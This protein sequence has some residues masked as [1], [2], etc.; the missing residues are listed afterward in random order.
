MVSIHRLPIIYDIP[1]DIQIINAFHERSG[2]FENP[3]YE[4][5]DICLNNLSFAAFSFLKWQNKPLRLAPF[6]SVILDTLWTKTFP[7]LLASRGAGKCIAAD[8]IVQTDSGFSSIK[9][10]CTG[11]FGA[12]PAKISMFGENGFNN[13][14]FTW[15]NKS[16]P[17]Y[18]ITTS[19]GYEIK[20]VAKHRV[21][22]IQNGTIEWKEL[23][24]FTGDEY[25]AISR[26]DSYTFNGD[27]SIGCHEAYLLGAIIGDGGLTSTGKIGFTSKDDDIV[28]QFTRHHKELKY[29]SSFTSLSDPIAYSILFGS[30]KNKEKFLEYYRI[31][32]TL[33]V[34]KKIP[35]S[36]LQSN[37]SA[38][39]NFILGYT[40]T[41]GSVTKRGIEY[42]S[43]SKELLRQLQIILLSYGIISKLRHKNVKYRDRY[44][45]AWILL[46]NRSNC[47]LFLKN[48]GRLRCA[49]KQRAL[50]K[51]ILGFKGNPNKDLMR[52]SKVLFKSLAAV[53][54]SKNSY[55]S[56]ALSPSTVDRY[57]Y[58]YQKA[59]NIL[60]Y[61][62]EAADTKEWRELNEMVAKNLYYDRVS[63][64]EVLPDEVTYDVHI[65]D[66]HTF[67]SNGIISH[68]TF[69]LAVYA[70]LKAMLTPGSKIVIVASSFRQS[71]LVFEYIEKLFEYSP[72]FR[73][74][75]PRGIK[76]PSDS[77]YMDVGTSSI[78]A[79]PLGNGEKI[80]GI[81]ATTIITD[82]F[83]SINPEI[84][85][86]VV[87]GFASVSSNPIEA[88]TQTHLEREAIK[89]GKM[90]LDQMTRTQGNQIIYSG[91]ANYQ[92]N[93]FYKTF[94]THKTII[95]NKISGSSEEV[96]ATLGLDEDNA[97]ADG[98]L[99]YR[100]YAIIRIP[101]QGLPE[102]YMDE[103]QIAQAK[104][105]MPKALFQMEYE[106][107]FPTDS[108]GF[109][110]R[111]T[112]NAATPGHKACGGNPFGIETE[113]QSG[114][115]YVMGIDPARKT[116]N[117]AISVL[118]LLP[119]NET[120]RNVYCYSMRGKSYT[121]AARKIRELLAKFNI[122]RIAMDAGGGGNAIMDI[123]QDGKFLEP[124]EVP[125][126]L[127]DDD[128]QKRYAGQHILDIVDFT[129]RWI[130]DANYGLAS[131]M[132]HKRL[133]FP[134]R[135]LE[136]ERS[137]RSVASDEETV[138]DDVWLEID[139][140]IK[141]T[142]MIVVTPTK[143][144]MQHFD[145]PDLPSSQQ[146]TLKTYQRKDR[147]SALLLATHAARTYLQQGQRNVTPNIG[148]WVNSL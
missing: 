68:N 90:T 81:R 56:K 115:Q 139:E 140:Q 34:S 70:A 143:T 103:K 2:K 110:K 20:G 114:F 67:I 63:S 69:M 79:L 85:Q 97:L 30:Q 148:G 55:L 131:D 24:T 74:C 127:Y 132:E 95:E 54:P 82:E 120:Y 73:A 13:T 45:D 47:K 7:I 27:W 104:V 121:K 106:C 58:S 33:S 91:T 98:H 49:R 10:L 32:Q 61:S 99:D 16:E 94:L 111:S 39:A 17:V 77:V 129:P 29:C 72:M 21:R 23:G 124:G 112:I 6:Q 42:S 116:D 8:S 93:H 135:G 35:E 25:L 76:K 1:K 134:Y 53:V 12:T 123:L 64:I 100:D 14:S 125:I 88:A 37:K 38:L 142:C 147:Y 107:A 50:E 87:R 80:R 138:R 60:M 78:R 5:I 144:G 4:L 126:W 28:E 141:E 15:V 51:L 105:T 11:K 57:D 31:P 22:V 75:C 84:F 36:I 146:S 92:F 130:R 83:A 117:F 59:K 46:I 128:E 145:I 41:D 48:V 108:D 52:N 86:V 89:Q 113:G 62:W 102:S 66:D 44:N 9:D 96:N 137:A 119:H 136:I 40:D 122:V 101:Y 3:Y 118:K 71:K 65:P 18:K 109:F 133:L 26:D 43:A 19:D